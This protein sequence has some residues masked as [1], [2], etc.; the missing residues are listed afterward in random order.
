MM[1]GLDI[2]STQ[3]NNDTRLYV[4]HTTSTIKYTF[5]GNG[6]FR[7]FCK[8]FTSDQKKKKIAIDISTLFYIK[9]SIINF[10]QLYTQ[11]LTSRKY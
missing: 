10:D 6:K 3:Q 2:N 11:I 1:T 8:L 9:H 4:L 7:N 5:K